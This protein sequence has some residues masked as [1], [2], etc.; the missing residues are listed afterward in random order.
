MNDQ[1]QRTF[2]ALTDARRAI[3]P[4]CEDL[5]GDSLDSRAQFTRK[6]LLEPL[7]SQIEH[8]MALAANCDWSE[9]KD[10]AR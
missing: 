4:A 8:T 6:R 5:I 9:G 10:N 1:K 7:L 2:D 3:A